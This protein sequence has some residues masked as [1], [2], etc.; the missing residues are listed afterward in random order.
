LPSNPS[1]IFDRWAVVIVNSVTDADESEATEPDPDY[2]VET[3]N[4][5]FIGVASQSRSRSVLTY[6]GAENHSKWI[7]TPLFRGSG[8]SRL[9]PP[10][11]PT[12]PAFGSPRN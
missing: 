9:V 2:E 11:P 4:T 1:Q 5:P 6:Y 8:T 3:S 7:Y 10:R 12:V